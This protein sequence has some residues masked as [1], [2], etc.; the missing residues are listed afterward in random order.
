[1]MEEERKKKK[2]EQP[3]IDKEFQVK[4]LRKKLGYPLFVAPFFGPDLLIQKTKEVYDE[5]EFR[6]FIDRI[7]RNNYANAIRMFAYG[8]WSRGT[9]KGVRYPHPKREGKFVLYKP[10]KPYFNQVL[11]RL[12]Y[13]VNA[14]I[15]PIIDIDDNCQLHTYPNS[16]WAKHWLNPRNNIQG[17]THPWSGS[18]YHWYEYNTPQSGMPDWKKWKATGDYL[19]WL[20]RWFIG[21]IEERF[22]GKVAYGHNEVHAAI[23]WHDIKAEV[24]GAFDIPKWRRLSSLYDR[25]WDWYTAKKQI[26]RKF[27][28]SIHG[29]ELEE[30][31]EEQKNWLPSN[32]KFLPS[33]DG[34][35]W[36]RKNEKLRRLIR[37]ILADRQLGYERNNWKWTQYGLIGNR[38]LDW[39]G[40]KVMRDEFLRWLEEN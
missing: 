22:R 28:P 13:I 35:I 24:Y 31:Y 16:H 26:W 4:S 15:M 8:V 37:A 21:E 29:I 39:H 18:W 17:D 14:G 2:K 38:E 12:E 20:Y 6:W 11:R 36:T 23:F 7:A 27:L 30:Q 33:G 32:I 1:M 34:H 10:H 40:A 9:E 25:S 19:M 5:D 3:K